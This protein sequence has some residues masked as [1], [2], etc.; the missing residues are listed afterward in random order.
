MVVQANSISPAEQEVP[1]DILLRSFDDIAIVSSPSL[2]NV[3][4]L[5]Y[6]VA[7]LLILLFAAG[8]RGWVAE[9][10]VRFQNATLAY[11][12]RRRSR[13]LEEIN[14]TRPLAEII[15]QI[16]DL[17]SFM[18]Q[19]APCWCQVVDG[20]QLGN[21]PRN[22]SAFRVAQEQ[23]HARSGPPL[24]AIYAAFDSRT[25]P[26]VFESETLSSA[27]KLTTLAI[28][29]RRLYSDLVRRS[30]F[31]LLTDIHNRFSLE[32]YLD[33]QI[34]LARQTA[35]I[36]ALI[37]IDLNDFKQVNDVYGHQVG[38]LY[39]QEAANR[40]KHQL[41]S[42]DMLARI[43]GDEFAVVLPRVHNRAEVVEIALRLE[44]CL[45]EPFAAEGCVVKGSASVGLALY[46]EDGA[47][48]DS[49]L[50]VADSAMYVNKNIR[51][52]NAGQQVDHQQSGQTPKPRA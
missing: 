26:R 51:R 10:K 3:R 16:T 41:R 27:A 19:S 30:E 11:S 28:E 18:L 8:A 33:Q 24:G 34:E 21:C 35:G 45:D 6:L 46:P 9:R 17:V 12:E 42:V 1:F 32:N 15:E 23:I 7:L 49:L 36:F 52:E 5:I 31:D 38:D 20:A 13:I 29:T 44:R 39:L 37:Y 4:N 43:G 40:M 14:S 48:K 47:T 22:L 50:S 2:L 25:K